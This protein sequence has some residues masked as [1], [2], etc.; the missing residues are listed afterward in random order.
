MTRNGSALNM[1]YLRWIAATRIR[2]ETIAGPKWQKRQVGNKSLHIM[3]SLDDVLPGRH[4]AHVGNSRSVK[5][6]LG[7]HV[8]VANLQIYLSG[9]ARPTRKQR[10]R[11]LES[12]EPGTN[13]H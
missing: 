2:T 6:R 9:N 5:D 3:I 7:E 12:E 13:L 8:V 10:R 4:V 1:T 11:E